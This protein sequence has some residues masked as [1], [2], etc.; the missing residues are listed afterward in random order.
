MKEF[1]KATK[2]N[3]LL[4]FAYNILSFQ[5]QIKS[6]YSDE[7][8]NIYRYKNEKLYELIL[9]GTNLKR[10][11]QLKTTFVNFADLHKVFFVNIWKICKEINQKKF[12]QF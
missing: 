3:I 11:L 10:N 1:G 8:F 9:S 7:L 5:S 2:T 6:I 12:Q 4:R